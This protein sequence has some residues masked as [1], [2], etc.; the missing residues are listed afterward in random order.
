MKML[1]LVVALTAFALGC[2]EGDMGNDTQSFPDGTGTGA[3]GV[4]EGAGGTG[5]VGGPG[6]AGTGI[7][8]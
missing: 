5:G 7:T 3:R 8:P 2:S 6:P 1:C 4:T